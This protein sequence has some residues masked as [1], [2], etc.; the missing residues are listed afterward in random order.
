MAA[1]CE[2]ASEIFDP[3]P[4]KNSTYV[5][6]VFVQCSELVVDYQFDLLK[7]SLNGKVVQK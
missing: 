5:D 2:L 4:Q 6:L 1:L 7:T 3:W